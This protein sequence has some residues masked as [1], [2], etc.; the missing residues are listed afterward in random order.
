M[1]NLALFVLA[2]P[3]HNYLLYVLY[4]YLIY[5]LRVYRMMIPL[6]TLRET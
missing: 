2:V 6:L 4:N 5:L 1:Q 3:A